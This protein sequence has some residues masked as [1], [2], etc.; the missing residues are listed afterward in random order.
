[1]CNVESLQQAVKGLWQ[2]W[3]WESRASIPLESARSMEIDEEQN[4]TSSTNTADILVY[5]ESIGQRRIQISEYISEICVCIPLTYT[6][7]AYMLTW[8]YQWNRSIRCP[9]W[10][11]DFWSRALYK[12]TKP[13]VIR[14]PSCYSL[15]LRPLSADNSWVCNWNIRRTNGQF[16]VKDA[17]TTNCDV[18]CSFPAPHYR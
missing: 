4:F 5:Y 8:Y 11:F 12:P 3:F 6:L 14:G 10:G 9:E 17:Y 7:Y 2:I 15:Q 1:M 16:C 13:L 18:S